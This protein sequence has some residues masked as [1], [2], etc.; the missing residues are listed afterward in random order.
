MFP[1]VRRS[2][3]TSALGGVNIVITSYRRADINDLQL[4]EW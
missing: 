3:A 4:T 2:T 1:T